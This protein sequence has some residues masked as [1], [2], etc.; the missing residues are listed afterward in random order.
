[1]PATPS[2]PPPVAPPEPEL[3]PRA[4]AGA[5]G[6]K[7]TS[8]TRQEV[9]LVDPLD[10]SAQRYVYL[11]LRPGEGVEQLTD[12]LA[13][14]RGLAGPGYPAMAAVDRVSDRTDLEQIAVRAKNKNVAKRARSIVRVN[15][16]A[17]GRRVGSPALTTEQ[18][19]A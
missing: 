16:S 4:P 6:P 3:Q 13:V 9:A 7:K 11:F 2:T 18:D 12:H 1:M 14:W 10:P 17:D 5:K 8:G 19:A 15:R